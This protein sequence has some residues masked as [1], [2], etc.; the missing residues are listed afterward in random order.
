MGFV[1]VIK[2]KAYFKRYQ[3]KFRRR[4]SGKTDYHARRALVIQ[5]K[6]KYE[7]P[8]HR[9]VVR[10]T[11]KTVICQIVRAELEGD[12]TICAAY[13]SELPR[14]GLEVGLKN[15][16]A[17]YCTGLLVAR[18]LLK[19]LGMDSM[20][21][22]NVEVT[23]EVVSHEAVYTDS[24][25]KKRFWVAELDE[26]RK[27]FRAFLDVGTR[28]TTSG[29]RLF[30][31]LKGA[32][33]GG[34][35]IPHS[36]G[37]FFGYD[38]E[39]KTLDAEV[40]RDRIFGEGVAEWMR[41]LEDRSPADFAKQFSQFVS[42]GITADDLEELYEKVHAAIRADPSP[43]PKSDYV[44]D[45]SYKRA[46]KKN[47]KERANRVAQKKAWRMHLLARRLMAEDEDDE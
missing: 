31:A 27:P 16:P 7:T 42:R 2:S 30:A 13:S 29:A 40:L 35:D 18:R 20:Y 45:K 28:A 11:N 1:K 22:G 19:Q 10:F 32:A 47:R 41:Q 14:Y 8:K 15:F 46:G 43:A 39:N 6:D 4:R 38:R 5:D 24:G 26:E 23:G 36:P 44:P 37:R 33:D 9:L 12:K 3:V 17:A 34:L 25:R 21:E